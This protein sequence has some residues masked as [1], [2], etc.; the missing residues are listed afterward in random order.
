MT[1][2]NYDNKT[3]ASV[4]NSETGARQKGFADLLMCFKVF[5]EVS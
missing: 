4:Q 2:I 5:I 3:F 1:K